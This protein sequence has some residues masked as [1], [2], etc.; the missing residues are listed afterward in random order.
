M[1]IYAVISPQ[2]TRLNRLTSEVFWN[3]ESRVCALK[4]FNKMG[5]SKKTTQN[6][7]FYLKGLKEVNSKI[8]MVP[9]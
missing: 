5:D 4:L 1:R 7:D 3:L 9:I 8:K 2:E 6:A